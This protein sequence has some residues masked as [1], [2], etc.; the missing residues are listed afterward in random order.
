MRDLPFIGDM[1][2][3]NDGC[4][5]WD[6]EKWIRLAPVDSATYSR[7]MFEYMNPETTNNKER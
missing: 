4:E 1:R 3:T 2:D 7:I 6:G 5:A